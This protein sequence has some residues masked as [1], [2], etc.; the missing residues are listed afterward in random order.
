[1]PTVVEVPLPQDALA[2]PVFAVTNQATGEGEPYLFV[3]TA[4]AVTPSV[5]T[6]VGAS[7]SPSV[8]TDGSYDT[9]IEFPVRETMNRAE[10]TF[11]FDKPITASSLSFALGDYVA[12]PKSISVQT[13]TADGFSYTVLAPVPLEYQ[14]SVQFPQTTASVW[15]VYFDYVQPLRITEMKINEN[16]SSAAIS[17]GLR[18][19]AQPGQEYALY[20]N[21]DH[22][23][24][25]V[26]KE[27]GDLS[28]NKGV[29]VVRANATNTNSSYVPADSDNDGVPDR[30]DNCVTVSNPDQKDSDGNGLGDACEDY[31]RDGVVNA[32]DNCP[33]VPNQDQID[34]DGDGIGDACDPV[35][36]RL[37][38]QMPWLPW[39]GIGVAGAVLLVLSVLAFRYKRDDVAPTPPSAPTPENG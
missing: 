29:V 24:P 38:E 3:T 30:I 22:Y 16:V 37:T 32:K 11:T 9:Y 13:D 19:L 8:V 35:D 10:V 34:T 15:H 5:V 6:A 27:S 14:N 1:V 26:Q 21:A 23:V 36:N 12:M 28:S 4:P 7:G 17:G 18:F 25:P 31:D 33:N 39:V 2:F 20:F